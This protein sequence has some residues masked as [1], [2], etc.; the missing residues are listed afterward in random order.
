MV[1]KFGSLD[2]ARQAPLP[3]PDALL[4]SAIGKRL[5]QLNA[6][7][8]REEVS[9]LPTMAFGKRVLVQTAIGNEALCMSVAKPGDRNLVTLDRCNGS[10]EQIFSFAESGLIFMPDKGTSGFGTFTTC[11]RSSAPRSEADHPEISQTDCIRSAADSGAHFFYDP[12][13]GLI[14][15]GNYC[16]APVKLDDRHQRP[17]TSSCPPN[18]SSASPQWR[19]VDETVFRRGGVQAQRVGVPA[20]LHSV[21]LGRSAVAPTVDAKPPVTNLDPLQLH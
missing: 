5:D 18:T 20:T 4:A 7:I 11:L 2:K 13:D 8:L 17:G 12:L 10:A 3:G 16:I 1:S 6:Q 14:H 19:L 15:Q 9:Q 21:G